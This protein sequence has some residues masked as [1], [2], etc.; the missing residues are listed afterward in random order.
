MAGYGWR[1]KGEAEAHFSSVPHVKPDFTDT[2][3]PDGPRPCE[4]IGNKLLGI[5]PDITAGTPSLLPVRAH[6]DS[7][8]VGSRVRVNCILILLSI[9]YIKT[10]EYMNWLSN[11]DL[12]IEL[13]GCNPERKGPTWEREMWKFHFWTGGSGFQVCDTERRLALLIVANNVLPLFLSVSAFW[14]RARHHFLIT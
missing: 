11:S 10:N 6:E 1:D 4:C 13:Y 14:L 8:V 5:A 2:L 7:D 12:K 9:C 3:I